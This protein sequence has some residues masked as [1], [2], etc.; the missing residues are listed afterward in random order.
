MYRKLRLYVKG[1]WLI[2]GTSANTGLMKEERSE[3]FSHSV[4]WKDLIITFL[5]LTIRIKHVQ[6]KSFGEFLRK[7]GQHFPPLCSHSQATII[8]MSVCSLQVFGHSFLLQCWGHTLDFP[9]RCFPCYYV[10]FTWVS[11]T[12][13]IRT[14]LRDESFNPFLLRPFRLFLTFCFQKR[15]CATPV[16]TARFSVFRIISFKVDLN[17]EKKHLLNDFR[18]K[19]SGW[20]WLNSG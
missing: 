14:R 12:G 6:Y 7:T 17:G 9:A 16:C 4:S 5:G 1:M 19:I 18:P 11:V 10:V 8:Y 3:G 20:S 13:Y 15:C 2:G